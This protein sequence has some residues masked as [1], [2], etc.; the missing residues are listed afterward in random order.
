MP[1]SFPFLT[2]LSQLIK[3]ITFTGKK[4]NKLVLFIYISYLIYKN[5]YNGVNPS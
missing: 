5:N 2:L 1:I 3:I 4:I